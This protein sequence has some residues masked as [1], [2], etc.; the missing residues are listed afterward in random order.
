LNGV[1][2]LQP[3]FGG[4]RRGHPESLELEHSS[5]RIRHR[6]VVVYDQ[7]RPEGRARRMSFR[8]CDHRI[9]LRVKDIFVKAGPLCVPVG[10]TLPPKTDYTCRLFS[11][12]LAFSGGRICEPHSGAACSR[13]ARA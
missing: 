5:E 9:I 4:E 11:G 8:R 7:D 3:G 10:Y 13:A 12:I 6:S 2:K 1:G